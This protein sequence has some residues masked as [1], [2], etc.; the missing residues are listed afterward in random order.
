MSR[1]LDVTSNKWYYNE[2]VEASNIILEDGEPLIVGIPYN[3]FEPTKPYIYQEFKATAGQKE[4][5]LNKAITPT[6]DNPLFVYINGVQTVY[7]EVAAEGGKTK[8]TLYSGAPANAIVAFASYGV[9]KLDEFGRP[10][11]TSGESIRYPNK[12]LKGY[13]NY[14]YNPFYRDKREYVSV[15]G[16]YLKR[17]NITQEEWDADPNRRQ[18]VLRKHIS[19]HDD[20]YFIAPDGILHVPYNLNGVTCKVTYLTNEGY[21]K[22]NT[23]EVT[24]VTDTILH[25]NRVFPDAY[26]TRAEA[27]VLV[28]RLRRTFYS[29]FSDTKASTH[30]L[31]VEIEAY[32][33]QRAVSIPG[34]YDVGKNDIEVY[35]NGKK[36]KVGVDYE[37]YDGYTIV[38]KNY[39]KEGDIVRIKREKNKSNHLADVGVHT[40][41]YRVDK[42]TYH[43]VNGT[44]GNADPRDDSWWAPHI[45]ALEQE[46]LSSGELMVNGMPVKEIT[47]HE[48]V[49]TVK[50]DSNKNPVH[51]GEGGEMWFMPNTFMTRAHAVT[52][53]NRFR[54]LMMERFL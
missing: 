18:E 52:I 8:V 48:G 34:R 24:P 6:N 14:Y 2:I 10:T 41:Y 38:F 28:D 29:R 17:A 27:F 15:F 21:I 36:Q 30:I 12:R 33:W 31:D 53:L 26:I 49:K 43:N 25:Y 47:E 39:L 7:K 3:V 19:Y 37:E 42:G 45:L 50:V 9:P 4:F 22:V 13:A 20:V 16:K 40:K 32:D 54:K 11:Q 23:E 1:F 35:L 5:T 51:Q 44:V 46:M